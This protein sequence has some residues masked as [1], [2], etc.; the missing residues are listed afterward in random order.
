MSGRG[1]RRRRRSRRAGSEGFPG[2]EVRHDP[3]M[4]LDGG[5]SLD[6]LHQQFEYTPGENVRTGMITGRLRQQRGHEGVVIARDDRH[7]VRHPQSAL[8]QKAGGGQVVERVDH[9]QG[10]GM[11]PARKQPLQNADQTVP[12]TFMVNRQRLDSGLLQ[13]L[14]EAALGLRL[15]GEVAGGMGEEQRRLA[16]PE[17]GHPP[18]HVAAHGVKIEVHVRQDHLAVTSPDH[19]GG[20]RRGRKPTLR[21]FGRPGQNPARER[22]AGDQLRQ[23]ASRLRGDVLLTMEKAQ[24]KS[25]LSQQGLQVIDPQG[26]ARSHQVQWHRSQQ[27]DLAHLP[28]LPDL[29]RQK[30]AMAPGRFGLDDALP[31]QLIQGRGQGAAADPKGGRQRPLAGKEFG[32]APLDYFGLEV[33]GD[34]GRQGLETHHGFK[35]RPLTL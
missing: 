11:V 23:G 24:P 7:V 9:H 21:R 4:R 22:I 18:G 26:G 34:L 19:H 13:D 5:A 31:L 35:K 20:N 6:D 15:A 25:R 10:R 2:N 33:V 12:R 8:G 14:P 28:G 1:C 3:H 16:M 30:N 27:A 32:P 17:R 29:R